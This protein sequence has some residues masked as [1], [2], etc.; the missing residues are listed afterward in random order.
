MVALAGAASAAVESEDAVKAAFVYNFSKFV[1][2]PESAFAGPTDPIDL[3][4]VGD[5]AFA[6]VLKDTV[7]DKTVK[8]RQLAVRDVPL[9]DLDACRI[10][11]IPASEQKHLQDILGH[12][13]NLPILIVGDAASLAERGGMIGLTNEENR[14]HFEVNLTAARRAGLR[15]GSQLLKVASHVVGAPQ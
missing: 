11:Y 6:A 4:V 7:R 10:I 1:E 14:V 5:N 9:D 3:C 2:W 8:G 13:N 15:L 12:V